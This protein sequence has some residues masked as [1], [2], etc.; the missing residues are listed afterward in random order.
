MVDSVQ[1]NGSFHTSDHKLLSYNLNIAKETEDGTEVRYDY[2]RMNTNGAREELQI[3]EWD[4]VLM[5]VTAN[6]NW[7]QLKDILFRIQRKHVSIAK[8]W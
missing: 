3:T 2:K 8:K 6:E 5:N 1:V 7:E 4:R